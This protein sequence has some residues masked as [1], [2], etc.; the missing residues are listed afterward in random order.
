M[1]DA[2]GHIVVAGNDNQ[3]M[4]GADARFEPDEQP[5]LGNRRRR[6]EARQAV[7]RSPHART[8]FAMPPPILAVS[9]PPPSEAY[10]LHMLHNMR[11]RGFVERRSGLAHIL[12][13]IDDPVTPRTPRQIHSVEPRFEDIGVRTTVRISGRRSHPRARSPGMSNGPFL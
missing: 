11:E 12:A 3:L 5:M 13:E 1:Q 4:V 2:E 6:D 10:R 8:G 7:E 9:F